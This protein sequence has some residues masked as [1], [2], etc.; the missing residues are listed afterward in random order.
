MNQDPLASLV[1]RINRQGRTFI[2]VAAGNNGRNGTWSAAA[3]DGGGKDMFAVGSF[4]LD[5]SYSVLRPGQAVTGRESRLQANFTWN[6]PTWTAWFDNSIP[7]SLQLIALTED[8]NVPNDACEKIARNPGLYLDKMVLIRRGGCLLK[9][10][11][12]NIARAGGQYVLVYDNQPGPVFDLEIRLRGI[13][14][15]GSISAETGNMLLSLLKESRN[16]RLRLGAS[17]ALP[18]VMVSQPN[19]QTAGKVSTFSTWESAAGG[20]RKKNNKAKISETTVLFNDTEFSRQT[21]HFTVTN[22]GKEVVEYNMST[23]S[24]AT[25]L[26]LS[27]SGRWP[28]PMTPTLNA[29]RAIMGFI[30]ALKPLQPV[31]VAVTITINRSGSRGAISGSTTGLPRLVLTAGQYATVGITPNLSLVESSGHLCPLCSGFVTLT[32]PDGLEQ[33][34]SYAGIACRVRDMPT[35]SP[36]L[37]TTFLAAATR[38]DVF[39]AKHEGRQLQRAPPGTSFVLPKLQDPMDPVAYASVLLPTIQLHLSMHTRAIMFELAPVADRRQLTPLFT[40]DI[41]RRIGGYG[42]V[43]T[44]YFHWTG[45]LPNGSW[46]VPGDYQVRISTLRLYGDINNNSHYRDALTTDSFEI[47]YREPMMNL[48]ELAM[49]HARY[50]HVCSMLTRSQRRHCWFDLDVLCLLDGVSAGQYFYAGLL[51][52]DAVNEEC[53]CDGVLHRCYDSLGRWGLPI[54]MASEAFLV[55][56]FILAAFMPGNPNP[57]APEMN[58]NILMHGAPALF[59]LVYYVFRGAHRYEGP[60]AYV[61]RLEHCLLGL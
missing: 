24:A 13:T 18:S 48:Q 10:K 42:R 1:S 39:M 46:A 59:S 30:K 49:G 44:H 23:T 45:I 15:G 27:S 9:D 37:N 21:Q 17:L 43:E 33:R 28:V 12:Q 26:S 19:L 4:D 41:S 16:V 58:W 53:Y 6:P 8:P 40:R 60:V 55:V 35:L 36:A 56:I 51:Q 11:I 31:D 20:S 2:A 38:Q 14:G 50:G 61:R 34:V 32:S 7:E 29:E 25:I 3:P 52:L 47:R 54:S 22:M 57:T 5:R